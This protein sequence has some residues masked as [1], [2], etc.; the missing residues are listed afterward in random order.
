M[1]L[2]WVSIH[3]TFV[4]KEI[5][6]MQN[7]AIKAHRPTAKCPQCKPGGIYAFKFIIKKNIGCK[8]KISFLSN[9]LKVKLF[10]MNYV[11]KTRDI[12]VNGSI[13]NIRIESMIKHPIHFGLYL[14]RGEKVGRN[15]DLP[16]V[17]YHLK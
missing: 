9:T 17:I 2:H 3:I 15:Q 8:Y 6:L 5:Q 7:T 11:L 13:E 14:L 16:R 10:Y 1:I 4:V 12:S